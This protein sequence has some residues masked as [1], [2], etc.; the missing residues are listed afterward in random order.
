MDYEYKGIRLGDGIEKIL[1]K[2]ERGFKQ[3]QE[4]RGTV[5]ELIED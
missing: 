5:H 4:G 2:L 1:D 3:L